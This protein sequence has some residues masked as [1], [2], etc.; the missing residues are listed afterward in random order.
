MH[1]QPG[2]ATPHQLR[3]RA[4][5]SR[6]GHPTIT[7]AAPATSPTPPK[8]VRDLA[9]PRPVPGQ[10]AGGR[11]PKRR[12][13]RPTPGTTPTQT[14]H[15]R[16]RAPSQPDQHSPMADP[17]GQEPLAEP[18][19][20]PTHHDPRRPQ[21]GRGPT[22]HPSLPKATQAGPAVPQVSPRGGG[23]RGRPGPTRQWHPQRRRA[24]GARPRRPDRP[25]GQPTATP[26]HPTTHEAIVAPTSSHPV[27]DPLPEAINPTTP[28]EPTPKLP[29]PHQHP[30][31]TGA[32]MP[33]P[34]GEQAQSEG[35]FI[36]LYKS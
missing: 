35:A 4:P 10:T 1:P 20:T 28:D 18:P 19:H 6:G 30:G 32:P 2:T 16:G 12:N 14:R 11:A 17:P 33:N 5:P 36:Q 8:A 24:Q 7:H 34:T 22:T 25:A 23:G 9:A 3:S 31:L 15:P 27:P 29:A 13:P 21:S 26:R